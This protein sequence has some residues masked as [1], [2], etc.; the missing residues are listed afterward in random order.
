MLKRNMEKTEEN[1]KN[2]TFIILSYLVFEYSCIRTK[3]LLA[4]VRKKN[5]KK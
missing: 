3:Y 5:N 4:F 1:L 2:T